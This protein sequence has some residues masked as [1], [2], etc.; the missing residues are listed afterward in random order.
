MSAN[1]HVLL[2]Y[3]QDPRIRA[4]W[5]RCKRIPYPENMSDKSTPRR[6]NFCMSKRPQSGSFG[7]NKEEK[8]VG[9]NCCRKYEQEKDNIDDMEVEN[10]EASF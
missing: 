9:L 3:P 7:L 1:P 6:S 5:K 10:G 8:R 4:N 2:N